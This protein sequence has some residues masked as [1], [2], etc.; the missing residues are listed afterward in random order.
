MTDNL[1][2]RWGDNDRHFGPFTYA[3]DKSYRSFAIVLGSADEEYPGTSLRLSGFGHTII[4]ALPEWCLRPYREKV[5]PDWDEATIERLGRDW[6]WD[7]D[8]RE[9]GF[10]ISEGFL[11]VFLGRQTMDSS[12]EQSWSCF[13][14]WTQWRH[15]R[16]SFYGLQGEHV[17]TLPDTGESHIG[18][19]SRWESERAIA[20]A[21]PTRR[22][23]FLDFDGERITATTRIEEREWHAGTGW[24]KWLS[25]FRKP[26]ISRSL[27]I[28][29]SSEVGPRK[30]SWKGGTLG[31]SIEMLPWEIHEVAFRRYCK[32]N[33]LTFIVTQD[34]LS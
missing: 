3:K 5:Y 33:N 4:L 6:Y 19:P 11:Q 26:K 28:Q 30:G 13:L 22:F 16:H 29:F 17:A 8:R 20:D 31:H 25:W 12:T 24:F 9:Y 23:D 7:I 14:P 21:T 15:V 2:R 1:L 27:D 34:G 32:E 18:N 10:S